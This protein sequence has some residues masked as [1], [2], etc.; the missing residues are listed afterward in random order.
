[1]FA[2]CGIAGICER[3]RLSVAQTSDVVFVTA[4]VFLFRG[5]EDVRF[6]VGS[7]IEER[8]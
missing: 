3:A 7:W 4:E 1:M 2:N 8:T 5:S 6:G